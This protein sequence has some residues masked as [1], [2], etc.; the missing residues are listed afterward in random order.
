MVL[1]VVLFAGGMFGGGV[2]AGVSSADDGAGYR[3]GYGKTATI[4]EIS[5]WD[6]DV[7]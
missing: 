5:G 7:R 6:I 2:F 3:Y 1:V 4:E